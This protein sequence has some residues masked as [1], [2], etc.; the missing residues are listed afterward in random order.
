MKIAGKGS[1][2]KVTIAGTLTAISQVIGISLPTQK[3]ETVEV[4]T[5]DNTDAAIPKAPTGRVDVG[6]VDVELYFDPVSHA[7]A[8]SWLNETTI[9]NITKACAILIGST[10]RATWSFDV[11]GI[12]LSGKIALNEYLKGSIKG[13]LGGKVT[14]S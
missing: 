10:P 9:A 13:T 2:F 6:E 14:V 3:H 12:E 11:A 8:T 4:D 5:L 1:V 7:F